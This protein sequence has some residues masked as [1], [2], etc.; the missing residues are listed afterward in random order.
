MH[1]AD[2]MDYF[3]A[4]SVWNTSSVHAGILKVSG[5]FSP[6]IWPHRKRW[7]TPCAAWT[8][9]A[10]PQSPAK[11]S[12][13]SRVMSYTF[14]A[15]PQNSRLVPC[16]LTAISQHVRVVKRTPTAMTQNARVISR[17]PTAIPENLR[18]ILWTPSSIPQILRFIQMSP[19]AILQN[20][21]KCPQI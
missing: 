2:S 18:S 12:Q 3:G 8:V 13:I 4:F 16:T 11:L 6:P 1:P 5:R 15:I 9:P 14:T 10:I 20:P 17:A 21:G 7:G 19:T